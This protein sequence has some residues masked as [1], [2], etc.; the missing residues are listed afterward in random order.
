L[1]YIDSGS[2]DPAEALGTWLQRELT[3]DITELRWQ[4]GFFSEDGLSA[5]VPT[6]HRLSAGNHPVH[7][8]I[9]S[10]DGDTLQAHVVRLAELLAI[11]RDNARFGVVYYGGSYYHPKTYH[12]TRGDR[13]EAAYVGSANLTMPG[14]SALHVEAGILLDTNLGDPPEVLRAVRESVDVWFDSNRPGLEVVSNLADIDRLTAAGVLA[15]ERIPRFPRAAGPSNGIGGQ[16]RPRLRPLINFPGLPP[17]PGREPQPDHAVERPLELPAVLPVVPRE[18]YPEYVLFA[19]D[20][21]TPTRGVAALSGATLP[22]RY[23]GIIFRL[24]RDSSRHWRDEAGTANV[25]IPVP[26]VTT[27]RFGIFRGRYERPRAEFGLEMR[28]IYP[29]QILR[30]DADTTNVMVYGFASGEPGH[31]DVRLVIPARPARTIK[32]LVEEHRRRM[33]ESGDTALLE[34]PTFQ[35]PSFRLTLLER[36][37]PLFERASEALDTGAR[38][39]QGAAWLEPDFSPPW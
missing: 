24:N 16:G 22:G 20:V 14:I 28:Y 1:R 2:R 33:P 37:S 15:P 10:N 34:W 38:V 13:T 9:G 11:P 23:V 7:A 18:P 17:R 27:L 31:S 8:L 21:A 26:T 29:G 3:P 5:F 6:I 19:P 30:S 32:T 36:G 12:L 35:H 4:S 39:G 25:S